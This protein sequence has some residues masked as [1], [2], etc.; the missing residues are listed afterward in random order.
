MEKSA[1]QK[2]MEYLNDEIRKA[3][4]ADLHRAA[5]FLHKARE[6]RSGSKKQRRISRENQKAAVLRRV[7]RPITW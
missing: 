1:R 3:M 2:V 6:V 7:D 5:D 4:T